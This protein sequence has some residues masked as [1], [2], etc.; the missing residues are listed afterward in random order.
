MSARIVVV[1][2]DPGFTD[3]LATALLFAGHDVSTFSDPMPALTALELVEDVQLL[4]TR[5]RFGDSQPVGL[6]LARVARKVRPDVKVVFITTP[7]YWSFTLGVGEFLT[8]PVTVT[9][10]LNMVDGLVRSDAA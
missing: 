9:D 3:A 5:M 2:D 10:V 6:S 7:D 4:I 8:M 1:H